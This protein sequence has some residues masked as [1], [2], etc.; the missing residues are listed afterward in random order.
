MTLLRPPMTSFRMP[1]RADCG[2]AVYSHLPL[3]TEARA[4]WLLGLGGSQ[5]LDRI[6]THP[7]P[8]CYHPK[9]N[10]L[11]FPPTCPLYYLPRWL[12]DKEPICQFRRCKRRSWSLGWEDSLEMKVATHSRIPAWE[13]PWTESL[14]VYSSWSR[15]VRH[16]WAHTHALLLASEWEQPDCTVG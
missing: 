9:Y 5:P 15:K 10:K 11:S 16:D 7:L 1:V 2:V 13:S 8:I 12:S 4:P 3:S 6:H 14:L